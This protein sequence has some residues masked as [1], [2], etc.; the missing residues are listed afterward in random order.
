[1]FVV[2]VYPKFVQLHNLDNVVVATQ[3]V[4]AGT[5]IAIGTSHS[6]VV[7]TDIQIGHKI[8]TCEISSGDQVTKYG[9]PIGFA[10]Q[11]I[12]A[13]DWVHC[14]N[15]ELRELSEDY[16]KSTEV[17]EISAVADKLP[18][19]AD[20][21][22]EGYRRADGRAGTR[23]YLCI[24]STVNCSAH[25]SKHVA[26]HF[27]AE[28]LAEYPN[29]DGVFAVT[30]QS[31]CGLKLRGSIQTM[32]NR[33]LSGIGRH[34]NVGGYLIIGLGCEQNAAGI[35]ME[36][37]GLVQIGES[38]LDAPSRRSAKQSEKR[39]PP[40]VVTMQ[41]L[42]GT[43]QSIAAGIEAVQGMLSEVNSIQR[44]TIS[45]SEI[46]LG[47]NCGGSDGSS[48]IT[49]NPALGYASDMLVA[50]GGT[51]ILAETT[52]IY[53][54]EHLLTRRARTTEVADK[55]IALIKWWHWYTGLYGEKLD[56]NP[57]IGNKA[58]GLTTIAEK[59]LGAVSKG[60]TTALN[61]V[62]QYAEQVRE[63]GLVVM[64]TP[65]F[66]PASVTGIVAGGANMIV[67]TTGMGSCFGCKPVPSIKVASN[68]PMFNRMAEDMD[69]NAGVV[70]EG[71]TIEQV[72][73]QIFQEILAVASGK[74]TKSELL[75]I[76]D[77]EFM[78][79]TVGPV[80]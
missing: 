73:Q 36:D 63:R 25:V 56:N 79:W 27:T 80:L 2:S 72:G 76:G 23:N 26:A 15:L 77:N 13:G 1:M 18:P 34:P 6:F 28:K 75:G 64:D 17:P 38:N 5:N 44:E 35:L 43:R 55:L 4:S 68:T 41:E 3:A 8:S 42:G 9:Q 54:A 71:A 50:C 37:E 12:A 14:H 74:P 62:Y 19:L 58:G 78:P 31:G 47:T 69:I 39:S 66:D 59:S 67:F 45:A 70:L 16:E 49:A 24:L 22:F 60:G 10:S 29:V 32:L 11:S 53:G 48:G 20:Y 21:T 40:P 51:S 33:V 46:V 7:R 30:H 52:E 65:G 57:S 61:E